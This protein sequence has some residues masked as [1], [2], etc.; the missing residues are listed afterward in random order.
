MTLPFAEM[1]KIKCRTA[2]RQEEIWVLILATFE[3]PINPIIYVDMYMSL[4]FREETQ[5]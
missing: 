2:L 4:K 5:A 3:M 1:G